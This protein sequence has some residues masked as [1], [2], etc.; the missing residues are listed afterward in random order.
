MRPL[1][2]LSRKFLICSQTVF[3]FVFFWE[4][5]CNFN[6]ISTTSL[7]LSHLTIVQKTQI[8]LLLGKTS[9]ILF[10]FFYFTKLKFE[11]NWISTSDVPFFN[12]RQ[13]GTKEQ[14]FQYV[15]GLEIYS[16]WTS[17]FWAVCNFPKWRNNFCRMVYS[18]ETSDARRSSYKHWSV[19][20]YTLAFRM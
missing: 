1:G 13:I 6:F 14:F 20:I 2:L 4:W 18:R 16:E 15:W 12:K 17:L 3:L 11:T 10:Y 9:I 5:T 19:Y 7:Q 8:K